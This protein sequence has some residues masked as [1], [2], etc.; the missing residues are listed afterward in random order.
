MQK[1]KNI[2]LTSHQLAAQCVIARLSS[3]DYYAN[4]DYRDRV[5]ALAGAG[6]GGFCV[7]RGDME[8]T[9]NM[10]NELQ[11][12]AET[13]LFFCADFEF[14]LPM[15]LDGGT[16]FPHAMA[17]G[18]N[19]LEI[20][21]NSAKAIAFESSKIGINWNLAPVCD[22]NSNINNPIINIRSF[23][24][25][26]EKVTNH[27]VSFM[28]GTQSENIL[29][30]C[31][32]FPGH[33]DTNQDSHLILPSLNHSTQI[34]EQRELVP[35]F[36]TVKAGVRS[37]MI[38]HLLVPAL[39]PEYPA[40]LSH[41][42]CTKLLRKKMNFDGLIITDGMEMKAI[43]ENYSSGEAAIKAIEAG[44]DI[45][46]LPENTDKAISQ[47]AQKAEQDEDFRSRL[48]ES[49]AR[50]FEQKQW[51]GLFNDNLPK[52][53]KV[54]D[55]ICVNHEKLALYA[56]QQALEIH[57]DKSLVPIPENVQIAG[58]ALLQNEEM[59]NPVSFFRILQ[60]AL[61][62]DL[63]F[64]FISKDIEQDD[65]L[66]LKDGIK[67][68]EIIIFAYFY[69]ARAYHGSVT[70]EEELKTAIGELAKGKKVI[71][72]LFGNPYLIDE[73]V[74]DT[75]LITYTDTLPG[76]AA[77]IMELSGMGKNLDQQTN[78]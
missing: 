69:R 30:C 62:N 3:E 60:Q 45:V 6:I 58:F 46:L 49:V 55:E 16:A 78:A 20:T 51:L 23:G 19:D 38:A 34:L 4:F 77:S 42:I 56:A 22:I 33:G 40:S 31:K 28:M 53:E 37:V 11:F 67:D 54:P 24:E 66:A 74:S 35:F 50:I 59:Q 48:E 7:F 76:I 10:I 61:E 27:A 13:K 18:K 75:T 8:K 2:D 32:H 17:L 39:D 70:I 68:A 41:T 36:H 25:D 9:A 63:D 15:R 26:I 65:L 57:G 1:E 14:G 52:A 73:I 47:L 72:I 43:S 44:C 21:Y 71:S 5:K 64:G 12:L 29:A